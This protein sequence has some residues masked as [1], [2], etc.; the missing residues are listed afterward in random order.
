EAHHMFVGET[1]L[2]R[3]IKRAQEVMTELGTDDPAAVRNAG[4]VDLPTFQRY[5]NFWFSSSLDLFGSEVSSNAAASFA[6]GLKGR[7]DEAQYPDHR[8]V[9]SLFALAQPAAGGVISV[10][11]PMRNAMN[12]ILRT[13]YTRDC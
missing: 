5:L 12:E 2:S 1:G 9:D 11:V 13:S 7:P 3:V 6:T 4:T 10:D 8:C